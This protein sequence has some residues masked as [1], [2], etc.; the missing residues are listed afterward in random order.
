MISLKAIASPAALDP[1]PLVVRVRSRT[2]AKADSIA[3]DVRRWIQWAVGQSKKVKSWSLSLV[4]VSTAL[5]YLS[6]KTCS[7]RSI[8]AK[9]VLFWGPTDPDPQLLVIS[10]ML[11]LFSLGTYQITSCTLGK[12]IG[13]K[14]RSS[15]FITLTLRTYLGSGFARLGV[16]HLLGFDTQNTA[17]QPAKCVTPIIDLTKGKK[18]ALSFAAS[19][20]RDNWWCLVI[21]RCRRGPDFSKDNRSAVETIGIHV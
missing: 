7:K 4:N 15:L 1:A 14:S 13:T 8:S 2:V 16:T 5:G 6:P 9:A 11:Y 17:N 3:L 10:L 19:V 18:I 20:I 12:K 21:T